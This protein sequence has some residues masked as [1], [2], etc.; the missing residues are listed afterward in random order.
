MTRNRV[1]KSVGKTKKKAPRARRRIPDMQALAALLADI[2]D[3]EDETPLQRAQNIVWDAWEARDKRKRVSLAKKALAISPLCADAYV[4]LALNEAHGAD[5]ALGLYCKGVKAGEQALGERAFREDAGHFWDI[6]ETRPY[7]RARHGLAGAL[8]ELGSHDE[9][10]AHYQAML[11]L[12]PNDNQGIRYL[13]IDCLLIRAQDDDVA[14]LLKR[15][16][17]DGSAHW[18]WAGVL[19]EF[20]RSGD[21]DR[22]CKALMR[23]QEANPHVAKYLL[24]RKKLP[25]ALPDY[26]SWGGED[27]AIAYAAHT[28][29]AA[30]EATPGALAWL[31][32]KCPRAP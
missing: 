30:W 15:Y 12:N 5:E 32:A 19:A 20:R 25:R 21:G 24:G 14:R 2:V 16:K 11:S 9:A 18:L 3:D 26:V 8:W 23:A 10:I 29:A 17:N 28:G 4:L 22:A 31:D 6:L 13:L 1:T 27:E 7:M